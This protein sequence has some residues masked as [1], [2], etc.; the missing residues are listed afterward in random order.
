MA[1]KLKI[2]RHYLLIVFGVVYFIFYFFY[3]QEMAYYINEVEYW[4]MIFSYSS[5]IIA[6]FTSYSIL[7]LIL[8]STRKF[9]KHLWK[10]RDSKVYPILS[11]GMLKFISYAN[12]II[13]VYLWFTLLVIPKE[14]NYIVNRSVSTVFIIIALLIISNLIIHIFEKRGVFKFQ[15]ANHLSR[16]ISSIIKKVLLVFLWVIGGITIISNLGYDVSALI[17]WAWIWWVAL[18]LGAQKSLTNVFW[19]MSIV[20]NKPFMIGDYIKVDQTKWVVKDIGISYLTLV[21]K[22]WH[23]VMIPNE[24]IISSFVE[25]YSVRETRRVD[26][27]IGLNYDISQEKLDQALYLIEGILQGFVESGNVKDYR[28]NFEEFWEYS[29]DVRVT[30]FSLTE[31]KPEFLDEKTRINKK[32]KAAFKK[33]EIIIAFPTRNLYIHNKD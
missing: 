13:S 5:A 19:A 22:Q 11:G 30:Y 4:E 10:K 29:L 1:S 6:I 25:N 32:I 26:L 7:S 15:F 28:V 16:H 33:E 24:A 18:A 3:L 8:N 14:Y 9:V 12:I 20:L 23:Q 21:D 17:T 31:E 2:L 27:S